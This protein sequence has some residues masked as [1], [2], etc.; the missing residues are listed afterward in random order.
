[1]RGS[2]PQKARVA[3]F[4]TE[5]GKSVRG[6]IDALSSADAHL[7]RLV[8]LLDGMNTGLPELRATYTREATQLALQ[9]GRIDRTIAFRELGSD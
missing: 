6:I 9:L 2:K 5:I 4:D 7:S 8:A 3:D 1:M